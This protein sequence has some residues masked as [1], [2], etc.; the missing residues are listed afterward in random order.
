MIKTHK[1]TNDLCFIVQCRV[2]STRM[3]NKMLIPFFKQQS[4]LDIVLEKLKINFTNIPIIVA[5]SIAEENDIL[6]KVAKK[7]GCDVYRGSEEKV[8]ERFID[9]AVHF[10]HNNIIR[11]CADNPFLDIDEM[12]RLVKFSEKN[13]DYDY[14]SFKVHNQPSIKSHFGFW[15]EYVKLDALKST[16][17]KTDDVFYHEHVTNYIYGNPTNY[18][19]KFLNV[20][21]VLNEIEDIRMTVD[22]LDDFNMLSDI[23][24]KLNWQYGVSYGIDEIIEFLDAESNYRIA[25]EKQIDINSK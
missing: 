8:L 10:K 15:S 14:I 2:G 21:P 20:K 19:I 22:T 7:Y 13:V 6:E 24:S 9:A 17:S 11:V 18:K 12:D 4:I 1:Y 3:P 16:A 23:Y 25:M 5:T